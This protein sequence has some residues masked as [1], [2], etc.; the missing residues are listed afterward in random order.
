M[1][2]GLIYGGLL[3]FYFIRICDQSEKRQAALKNFMRKESNPAPYVQTVTKNTVEERNEQ[4]VFSLINKKKEG[5]VPAYSLIAREDSFIT[6][7]SK[8]QQSR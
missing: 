3:V 7:K 2:R 8:D 4:V 5:R 6:A 1:V